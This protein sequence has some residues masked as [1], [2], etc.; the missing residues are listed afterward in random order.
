MSNTPQDHLTQV[1]AAARD[2]LERIAELQ[3]DFEDLQRA[4]AALPRA[5]R[6]TARVSGGGRRGSGESS[7]GSY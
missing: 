5:T 4:F 2:L 1:Q 3:S 6:E 7:V